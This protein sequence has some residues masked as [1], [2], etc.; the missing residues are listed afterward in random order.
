MS[1]NPFSKSVKE[2]KAYATY[3]VENPANGMYLEWKVL[4]T[5][6]VKVNEDKTNMQGGF[7]LSNHL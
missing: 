4:K 2:D 7:V 3:R 6:K 1:K 5:Y